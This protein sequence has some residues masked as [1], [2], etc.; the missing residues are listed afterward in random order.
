M[1]KHHTFCAIAGATLLGLLPTTAADEAF[2]GQSYVTKSFNALASICRV[3][4]RAESHDP[5]RIISIDPGMGDGGFPIATTNPKAQA[6]FNYG[7]KM[8]HAFYHDDARL[9]FDQAVAA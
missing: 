8:F 7:I 1:I 4:A 5:N 6:W 3:E 2:I 9:A